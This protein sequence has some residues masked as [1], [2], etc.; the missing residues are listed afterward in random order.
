MV[1]MKRKHHDD[2]LLLAYLIFFL[3]VAAIARA[4]APPHPVAF[5]GFVDIGFVWNTNQPGEGENFIPG[6]GTSGKQANELA[7]NLAQIQWTRSA[8]EAQPVGFT[9]SLVAGDGT[10]IVHAGEP[11]GADEFRYVYQASLAF[12]L[13]NGVLVEA[14]IYPSHIGLESLYSKDN[15]NYT[16]SWLGELSP[17]YQTGVKVS[18]GFSERWSGQIHLL[19]GWQLIHDNNDA[20]AVGTQ[21]AYSAGPV[22]ASLNTFVG[23][24]LPD[25]DESLRSLVDLLIV[26]RATP[27]LQLGA[28]VDVGAQELPG[29]GSANWDGAGVYAR[30]ALSDRHALALRA[31]QFRDREAGISG[32]AQTL[33]E[34]TLTY[35]LRARDNFI[36]K[37]ETRYDRS[38]AMVFADEEK[39]QFI[40]LAGAAVTF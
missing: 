37:L 28:V 40:A 5:S 36:L 23:A 20:R 32:A 39:S 17:Y 9:L 21:I 33:R 27:A 11:D 19:N 12:L 7:L 24:E 34:V 10:E 1:L 8:T 38:T 30:Q 13:P 26:Y 35:E 16:R 6:T 31:E 3:L 25:D 15:F 4:E 2:A 29:A 22:F 18:Y 14:G